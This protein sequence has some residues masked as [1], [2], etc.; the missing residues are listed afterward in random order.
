MNVKDK[1]KQIR[2]ILKEKYGLK[3]GEYSVRGRN[4][5]YDES[6]DVLIRNPYV[7]I[8]KIE[9]EIKSKFRKIRVCEFSGEILGGCN[10][11][12]DVR[13]DTHYINKNLERLFDKERLDIL[14]ELK[15][16]YE[17]GNKV[18]YLISDDKFNEFCGMNRELVD[19]VGIP[20]YNLKVILNDCDRLFEI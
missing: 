15:K 20:V 14:K 3:R 9:S 16:R 11:Y 10:T 1:T 4:V 6:I 18:E 8:N 17:S 13:L 2:G 19:K 5:G 7:D 12:V